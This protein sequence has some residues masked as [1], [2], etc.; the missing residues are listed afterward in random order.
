MKSVSWLALVALVLVLPVQT[1]A[2]QI[3]GTVRD[4]SSGI[5]VANAQVFIEAL[6]IGVLTQA[7]GQY[8]L[9]GV[10]AGTQPRAGPNA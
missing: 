10:P 2:Q 5:A 6:N 8:L 9:L 3:T 4:Q 7:S 1:D